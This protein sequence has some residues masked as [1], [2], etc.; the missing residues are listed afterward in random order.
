MN[1]IND[2][3]FV[4]H[5]SLTGCSIYSSVPSNVPHDVIVPSVL[6]PLRGPSLRTGACPTR[7]PGKQV[8]IHQNGLTL[9]RKYHCGWTRPSLFIHRSDRWAIPDVLLDRRARSHHPASRI[10]MQVHDNLP[11]NGQPVLVDCFGALCSDFSPGRMEVLEW[12][13]GA[14]FSRDH[15]SDF[16]VYSH[17]V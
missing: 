14:S 12:A 1:E 8:M 11:K 9:G 10:Y 5:F 6:K 7:S 2:W 15:L 13:P 4:R 17:F 16:I 3:P